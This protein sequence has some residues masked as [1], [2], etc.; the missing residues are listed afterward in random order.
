[1]AKLTVKKVESLIKAGGNKTQRYADGDG[2]YLVVPS[3]GTASWMLRFTSNKKRRE[4]T[5]AKV[6]DLT[7]ANARLEAATKMKQVRDGFDPLIQRKRAEQE[8]IKTVNDLFNDWY[9]TLVKRLKYPEIPKRV[10]TKD[11]APVIGDIKLDQISAR[12]I[13][14][15]INAIT[16]AGKPTIA[17]DALGYCKQLFNH[18]IKLDLIAGNP[19]SAFTVRDAGGVEKSKDRALTTSELKQFFDTAK[20]NPM[21]FTRDNYLA[22]TLLVCLGVRKS[23]LCE[24]KWEEFDLE[25]AV[26]ELPKERSKTNVGLSIP[27]ALPVIQWFEELK[28]RSCG[29][30]YVFPSRRASKNPHMGPDTLNR[31]ITKLFGHEPGK[32]KQPPNLMGDM[33]HFTVHDLRRTCRTLLAQQGTPGYVAERCLNHKLKGVEGIY[34]KYDYFEERKIALASLATTIEEM[35]STIN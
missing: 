34:D 25:K 22:C 21:S 19:A 5:L 24:A 30:D 17:N 10:Y 13:R 32:K 15:T 20:K 16:A 26:W 28:M 29:S 1:M 14:T 7:L 6:K 3:S 11:I 8:S 31:A 12:D 18:A 2:L 4:M 35:V 27:L 33:P 23:E 9:P